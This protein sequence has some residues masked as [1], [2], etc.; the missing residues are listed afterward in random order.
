M[1]GT[2]STDTV[3]E[4]ASSPCIHGNC[5]NEYLYYECTC[6]AGYTGTNCEA[7]KGILIYS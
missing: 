4:C 6:E 5:S 2:I 3:D 7:G 1:F